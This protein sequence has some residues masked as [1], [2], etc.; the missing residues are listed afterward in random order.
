LN[1]VTTAVDGSLDRGNERDGAQVSREGGDTVTKLLEVIAGLER[2]IDALQAAREG[3][4]A[5]FA[6]T[7][8][9]VQ[10]PEQKPVRPTAAKVSDTLQPVS[11]F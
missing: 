2:K 7:A 11:L 5:Q 9:Q 1:Y 10:K 8:E 4:D 6:L 3:R